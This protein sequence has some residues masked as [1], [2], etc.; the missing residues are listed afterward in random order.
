MN[1]LD[2]VLGIVLVAS[3]ASAMFNGLTHEVVRMAALLAGLLGGIWFY[4]DASS[5]YADWV[6]NES[7][8]DFAGF[9][10][11]LLGALGAGAL[12]TW[13][14]NVLWKFA[15]VRWFDRLLGGAFG[16]A[17]GFVLCAALV[18]G[19]LAFVP[20]Q[21]AERAVANSAIAP[22]VLHGAH[23]TVS[24]APD[25]LKARFADGFQSVQDMWSGAK[26]ADSDN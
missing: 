12:I 21:G 6:A 20:V 13:L 18:L 24:L 10:T 26:R 2:L 3:A 23:A 25:D 1:W 11:I 17:R 15:G 14:M 4:Q 19:M 9:A 5:L 8:R 22:V 7:L 16:L